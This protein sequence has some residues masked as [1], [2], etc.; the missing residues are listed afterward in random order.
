MVSRALIATSAE[1][2]AISSSDT[3]PAMPLKT[4]VWPAAS[5]LGVAGVLRW[6]P[7][8]SASSKVVLIVLGAA[9]AL[10]SQIFTELAL[11]FGPPGSGRGM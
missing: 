3:L 10:L 9:P 8:R 2:A 7:S 4:M 5:V 11:P 6:V 1:S